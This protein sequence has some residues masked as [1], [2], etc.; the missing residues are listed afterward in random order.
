RLSKLGRTQKNFRVTVEAED[1]LVFSD[2]KKPAKEQ[3]VTAI[4]T[5]E[6]RLTQSKRRFTEPPKR[7]TD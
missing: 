1:F 5:F 6:D 4:Q 7:I 3:D 2:S